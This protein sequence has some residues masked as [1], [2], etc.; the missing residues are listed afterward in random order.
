MLKSASAM[1]ALSLRKWRSTRSNASTVFAYRKHPLR[2][3]GFQTVR[4]PTHLANMIATTGFGD[5]ALHP[6]IA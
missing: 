6:A 4:M 1:I 3:D 5:V 2:S